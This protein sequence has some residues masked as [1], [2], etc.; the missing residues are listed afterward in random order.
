VV[1]AAAVVTWVVASGTAAL[2]LL[3]TAG[4]LWVASPL[5]DAF[6]SGTDNPRLFLVVAAAVVVA[7]SVAADIVAVFVLRGQ[8]WAQWG[9]VAL[10]VVAAFGGV[11]SAYYIGP[12]IVTAAATAVVVLLLLPDARAWFRTSHV[13]DRAS[14]R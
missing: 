1:Y 8:A 4:L 9:L 14:E 6:D 13:P 11:I 5:F 2:T 10:S 12:L 7:L 3:L